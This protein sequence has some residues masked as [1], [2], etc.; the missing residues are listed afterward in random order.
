MPIE[1]AI[2]HNWF[3]IYFKQY[4]VNELRKPEY[5]EWYDQLSLKIKAG[6]YVFA[7]CPKIGEV[8]KKLRTWTHR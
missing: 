4:N 8:I 1:R 7:Y 2:N 3:R 5:K 6:L